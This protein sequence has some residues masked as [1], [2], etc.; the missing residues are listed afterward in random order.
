MVADA[1]VFEASLSFIG[2]GIQP[3]NPSW[4]SVLADGKDMVLLGGW[5]ATVFPGALI[6]VTVLSLNVLSEGISDVPPRRT[7]H[8]KEP[9]RQQNTEIIPLGDLTKVGER[10]ERRVRTRLS[11]V[12]DLTGGESG[13]NL[14]SAGTERVGNRR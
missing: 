9:A 5:W 4:G 2:A 12:L 14:V 13:T 10:L 3:P 8:T 1:I 11:T 7:S 6:L